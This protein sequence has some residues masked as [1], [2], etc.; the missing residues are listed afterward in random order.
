MEKGSIKVTLKRDKETKN[1]IRYTG[2][3]EET[4]HINIYLLKTEV[5]ALGGPGTIQVTIAPK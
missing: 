3:T 1:S 5:Q 2:E 4:A